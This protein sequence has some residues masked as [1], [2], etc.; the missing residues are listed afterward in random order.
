[1]AITTLGLTA[2]IFLD[3]DSGIVFIIAMLMLLGLGFALFSSPNTNAVMS[4]VKQQEYGM[5]SATLG[6]MRLV[7]QTMSMGITLMIFAVIMGKGERDLTNVSGLIAGIHNTFIT[8]A[9]LCFIGIFLS[10]KRGN[11]DLTN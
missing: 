3:K 6:T 10:V 7:G 2:F 11:L 8:F 1:M 5:A 4:S 9:I